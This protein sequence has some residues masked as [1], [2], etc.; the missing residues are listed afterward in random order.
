MPT[1][2]GASILTL[3]LSLVAAPVLSGCL[4]SADPSA[5][6]AGGAASSATAA[7]ARQAGAEGASGA[8][9]WVDLYDYSVMV[10]GK[11]PP[12]GA[13]DAVVDGPSD[14]VE[15]IVPAGV[16]AVE[17]T[18]SGCGGGVLEVVLRDAAGTVVARSGTTTPLPT[19]IRAA[20][21]S[22]PSPVDTLAEGEYTMEVWLA[23]TAQVTSTL[24]V[25]TIPAA[26]GDVPE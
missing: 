16:V 26:D 2:H 23:G 13:T 6:D 20:S 12:G 3:L 25:A 21:L 17:F 10:T 9:A 11:S 22:S 7:G 18:G 8:P 14:T 15:F 19:C 5:S 24:R 4:D 1:L